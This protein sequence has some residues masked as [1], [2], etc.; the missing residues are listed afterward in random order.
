MLAHNT[1]TAEIGETSI[2]IL[3]RL[4]FIWRK[5]RERRAMKYRDVAATAW[6]KFCRIAMQIK[7]SGLWKFAARTWDDYCRGVFGITASRV[8][9]YKGALAYAE[10]IMGAGDA[11][12]ETEGNIRKL[13]SVVKADDPL[14]I[15]TYKA[16]MSVAADLG[17]AT[18]SRA[19]Y[20][21]AYETLQEVAVT[22]HADVDGAQVAAGI[23]GA[24]E[25]AVLSKMAEAKARNVSRMKGSRK[26]SG[27]LRRLGAGWQFIPAGN[28]D[29]PDEI[30]VTF[31]IRESENATASGQ[32]DRN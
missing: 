4:T 3:A 27:T 2:A 19:I 8:R 7:Q 17:L 5:L 20:R 22:G 24:I 32:M 18:P 30:E 14:M 23:P 1:T 16:A 26:V 12:E 9:Q 10:A 21:H 6:M 15:G 29:L 28:V 25:G 13:R 11:F 31:Y